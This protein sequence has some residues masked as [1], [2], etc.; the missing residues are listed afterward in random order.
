MG[1]CCPGL[2]GICLRPIVIGLQVELAKV[3]EPDKYQRL[4][5]ELPPHCP[6]A[7]TETDE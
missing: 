6:K 1:I 4:W 2:G 3:V 7:H 5:Y